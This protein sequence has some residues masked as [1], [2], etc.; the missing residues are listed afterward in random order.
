MSKDLVSEWLR[1]IG[2]HPPSV[3]PWTVDLTVATAPKST[4]IATRSQLKPD[5]MVLELK[6][7]SPGEWSISL[8]RQDRAFQVV[9][10]AGGRSVNAELMKFRQLT[11]WPSCIGPLDL[12]NL[13]SALNKLSVGRPLNPIVHIQLSWFQ[14]DTAQLRRSLESSFQSSEIK[15]LTQDASRKAVDEHA[16]ARRELTAARHGID[17]F[18]IHIGKTTGRGVDGWCFGLPPALLPSHWPLSRQDGLP[19][20]H[21]FTLR[22]PSL[23]RAKRKDY[24]ALTV[25][26]ANDA[27]TKG[28][29]LD[30]VKVCQANP[31]P[32]EHYVVDEIGG[33]WAIIWLTEKEFLAPDSVKPAWLGNGSLDPF[34]RKEFE[35]VKPGRPLTLEARRDDPN[36]GIAAED[37]AYIKAYSHEGKKLGLR[38]LDR[39]AHFGG[40][41]FPCQSWPGGFGPTY[42]EFDE[43]LGGANLGGDGKCQIDLDQMNLDWSCG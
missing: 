41:A 27:E 8:S 16:R 17:A 34:R 30:F 5:D 42:L 38:D 15:C 37:K 20:R 22:V 39:G 32:T 2:L 23:Y 29:L 24:A 33:G 9:W 14:E 12:G 40:T 43:A 35:I 19:M 4:W 6:V 11:P 36:G 31:H 13:L 25:F 18:D 28:G 7:Q 10:R 21:L 1:Q 26:Q 3:D